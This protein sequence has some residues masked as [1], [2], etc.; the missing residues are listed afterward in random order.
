MVSSVGD[1]VTWAAEMSRTVTV[2]LPA[3]AP[4]YL[5][6]GLLMEWVI[7]AGGSSSPSRSR[8]PRTNTCCVPQLWGVNV[9]VPGFTVNPAFAGTSTV[10]TT[11]PVGSESSQTAYGLL[12]PSR[13]VR[14]SLER[15]IPEVSSFTI[16]TRAGFTISPGWL[17]A[18]WISMVSSASSTSSSVS[19]RD[20]NDS[21]VDSS[22]A[23]VNGAS[24]PPPYGWARRAE[25]PM[26]MLISIS[27][28]SVLSPTRVA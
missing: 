13:T 12:L 28:V 7:T 1:T 6:S 18:P 14:E 20:M 23:M 15:D 9:R 2:T 3:A 17:V 4:S 24:S 10:T 16:V 8:V 21:P 22:A 11:V 26:V 5:R 25:F 27:E 19:L